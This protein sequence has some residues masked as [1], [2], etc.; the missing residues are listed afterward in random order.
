MRWERPLLRIGEYLVGRAC[1]RL[2]GEI[3]DERY[4]EWAAEL[5][6]ILRDP[7]IRLTSHRALRMLRYAADTIR[8]TALTPGKARRRQT[9]HMTAVIGLLIIASLVGEALALWGAV[10]AP[11]DW[12]NYLSAAWFLVFMPGFIG[13]RRRRLHGRGRRVRAR[14]R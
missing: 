13:I 2:P 5:P 14:R 7:D 9:A 3:R 4:R 12:V 11:G 8:G 1:R 10:K 6:A